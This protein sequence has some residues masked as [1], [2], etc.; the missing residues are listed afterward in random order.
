MNRILSST[1]LFL[2]F[3]ILAGC[4]NRPESALQVGPLGSNGHVTPTHQLLRPAGQVLSFPGRPVDLTLS[5]D[6]RTLFVKDMRSLI[7]IDV[8]DWKIRQQLRLKEGGASPHGLAVSRDGTRV[9]LTG[10]ENALWEAF[11]APDGKTS[12]SRKIA[13]PGPEGKGN[14]APSGIAISPDGSRAFVC[15]SRNNSL[16]VVDLE[17]GKLLQEFPVGVA[18]YDVA[19]DAAGHTAFVSNWGGRRA[20]PDDLTALSSGTDTVI[21]GRG[22]ASDGTV[23]V[24]DLHQ[25]AIVT[26]ITTGL[27]PCDLEWNPDGTLL[28]VANANSDSVTIIDTVNRKPLGQIDV[29]PNPNL[30]FGSAPNGLW[31][32][33]DRGRLYVANGGNNAVAVFSTVQS[34]LPKFQAEG[35]VPTAWYPGALASEGRHLFIANVKGFGSR[36]KAAD[37]EG[38]NSHNHLGAVSKVPLPSPEELRAYTKQAIADARVPEILRN[39]ER[40]RSRSRPVPVPARVGEPSVFEHIVYIIKENRTYDQ[41]L[42]DLP[43]GNGDPSL[44]TFGR[45]VTPNHHALAEEFVLLDNYYCNGILSADGHAWSTE[46]YVTDYIEK[47]FGGFTRSY[48]FSGDDPISFASSGFLW[49]NVLQHGL[50]FRN[51]G[52]MAKSTPVPAN[53]SFLDIFQDHIDGAGRISFQHDIQI[54]NLRRYSCPDS[55]GWNMKIPDQIRAEVFLKEFHHFE[56]EGGFPNLVIIYLPSDHTSGTRP[57]NPT[58]RAQVADNDLALGRIVEAITHSRFWPRTCIFAIE[59]DPQ[60]GYDHVD[61]HRSICLVA[62]PYTRR[63]AVVSR[64]YNQTSVLHTIQRMLG[65]PAMNQMD[66]MAPLMTECFTPKPDLTPYSCRTNQVSL[67][68]MNRALSQLEGEE[69]H[70]ALQSMNQNWDSVDKADEDT[71]NRIIWHAVKGVNTPYPQHLAGAHGTGLGRL[72]LGFSRGTGKPQLD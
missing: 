44:C 9:Y 22:I 36:Q 39:S 11:V 42:G 48:P 3:I 28:F 52:E 40:N 21:D 29:R 23:S 26:H 56:K 5:P 66:A 33:Q 43:Q 64:F 19:L 50:S 35:L 14:S 69:L 4:Q 12:W 54:A 61:G 6:G 31:F 57:G 65:I 72:G 37:K 2:S 47:S 46:G 24:L 68:E 27:H 20:E 63:S 30:P 38:W 62:S 41:L 25:G 70:W 53:T 10:S 13:L 49:D 58:P 1:A 15:L 16:G 55:P 32:D 34:T 45:E 8:Q 17:A 60:N 7:T 71:L 67:M 18:P 51:Y 59:D